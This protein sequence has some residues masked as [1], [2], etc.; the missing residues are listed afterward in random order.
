MLFVFVA[1]LVEVIAY[2]SFSEWYFRVG[3]GLVKERW[4]TSGTVED[5]SCAVGFHLNAD[6]LVGRQRSRGICLRQRAA[7]VN[8][9]PRIWLWIE[10]SQQGAALHFEV[11]PFY[12]VAFLVLPIV[13][14]VTSVFGA[15]GSMA[16]LSLG[17]VVIVAS[18]Y[19]WIM[20]W[21]L[22]RINRLPTIR[23]ALAPFGQRVCE[24]CGYDL[25]G[26]DGSSSCP[27]CDWHES[28]EPS[29]DAVR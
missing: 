7:G 27:E 16:Y 6:G 10:D 29:R 1:Y 12:S 13:W 23:R 3:P 17:V 4:Q 9:W 24:Q 8:A 28:A 5:V 14:L 19:R 22:R 25:F 11:R 21:D 26:H 2:Y 20:P 18:F 15:G